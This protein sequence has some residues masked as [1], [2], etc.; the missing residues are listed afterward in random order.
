MKIVVFPSS[1]VYVSWD[2]DFVFMQKKAFQ[3]SANEKK[4]LL[5]PYRIK[6]L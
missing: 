2:L 5:S 6:V 3:P 1:W 4:A